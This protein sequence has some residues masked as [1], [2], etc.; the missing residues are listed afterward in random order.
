VH[1][2]SIPGVA[3]NDLAHIVVSFYS[4][5][6]KICSPSESFKLEVGSPRELI[7]PRAIAFED[8]MD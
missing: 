4:P 7:C 8:A 5:F 6:C 1:P 2:G 3:S